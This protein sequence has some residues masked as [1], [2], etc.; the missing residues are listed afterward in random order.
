MSMPSYG[1]LEY[2]RSAIV[3]ELDVEKNRGRIVLNQYHQIPGYE[4]C[5][6]RRRYR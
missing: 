1:L 4:T 5:I 2:S 6:R 3:R